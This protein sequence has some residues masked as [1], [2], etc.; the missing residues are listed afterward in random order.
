MRYGLTFLLLGAVLAYLA[1]CA[2]DLWL[3]LALSNA[4]LC[5]AVFGLAYL[6]L[7]PGVFGKR[8][9]GTLPLPVYLL[10]WPYLAL[11]TLSMWFW[12][13]IARERAYDQITPNLYLGRRLM[14][15]DPVPEQGFAAV[16]DLTCEYPE[17]ADLRRCAYLCLPVLDSRAPT[18]DQLAQGLRFIQEHMR[19]GPV[20]VHCALGHGRSATVVAAY[21][22]NA[23]QAADEITAEKVMKACR[24]DVHLN[25][26]QRAAV[27][28]YQA[29]WGPA[30][31]LVSVHAKTPPA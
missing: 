4:A 17:R 1:I 18:V 8:P 15:W 25:S 19:T 22:L 10:F 11:H 16:L 26:F 12:A 2:H 24:P 13:V 3:R 29:A 23:G 28:A 21:L 6:R 5:F 7:G 27:R 9:D 30:P 20:L 31:V 14:P